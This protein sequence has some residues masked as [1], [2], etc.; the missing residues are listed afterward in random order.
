MSSSANYPKESTITGLAVVP[1]K[2]KAKGGDKTVE[3]YAFLDT[4]KHHLLH[5]EAHPATWDTREKIDALADNI[6]DHKRAD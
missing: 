3:T 1:V 6:R 5:R 4:G 2:V